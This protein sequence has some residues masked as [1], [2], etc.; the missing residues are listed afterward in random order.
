ME[1]KWW[2]SIQADDFVREQYFY[3]S[4]SSSSH[5]GQREPRSEWSVC[6]W[7]DTASRFWTGR[8]HIHSNPFYIDHCLSCL[9]DLFP[10]LQWDGWQTLR[11]SIGQIHLSDYLQSACGRSKIPVILGELKTSFNIRRIT[12]WSC[13]LHV[14]TWWKPTHAVYESFL[15]DCRLQEWAFVLRLKSAG[16]CRGYCHQPLCASFLY[17]LLPVWPKE[18]CQT[19]RMN[20]SVDLVVISTKCASFF[21]GW[22]SVPLSAQL[23]ACAG[24]G[25][26]CVHEI[27]LS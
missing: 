8:V 11:L 22:R 21:G 12:P 15:S 18:L 9:M 16:G 19:L 13:S 1:A 4:P 17:F 24:C 3:R 20:T 14:N 10:F 2:P 23:C 7:Q 25:R 27:T 26:V 6:G 5:Q